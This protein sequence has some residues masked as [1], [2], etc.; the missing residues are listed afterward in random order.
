[1]DI[2]SGRLSEFKIFENGHDAGLAVGRSIYA[3]SLMICLHYS[4][5]WA[6]KCLSVELEIHQ[7]SPVEHGDVR[8]QT[9]DSLQ[10]SKFLQESRIRHFS[11]DCAAKIEYQDLQ[12]QRVVYEDC[13]RSS[14]CEVQNKINI[15]K[16][17]WKHGSALSKD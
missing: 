3:L 4:L 17:G 2:L 10:Q 16:R 15:H 9:P 5:L 13:Q 11:P 12:R 14:R 6:M 8:I 7:P 1:L